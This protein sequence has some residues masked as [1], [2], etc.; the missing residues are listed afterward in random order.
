MEGFLNPIDEIIL[1]PSDNGVKKLIFQ[2]GE[3]DCPLKGQEVL[4]NYEG[5]LQDGT[6][7]DSSIN[8]GEPLKVIIGTGQVIKGWDIG[9]MSMQLGERAELHISSEYAYGA[10]GAPPS[11]PG[12]ANLIFKVD[13]L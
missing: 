7:F 3:G 6:I 11:I 4:V 9:I 2:K 13:L 1:T 5:R 10:I 12:S 8:H